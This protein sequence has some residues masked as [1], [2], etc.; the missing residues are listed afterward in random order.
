M[1]INQIMNEIEKLSE[2]ERLEIYSRLASRINKREEILGIL[3]K[4]R[5]KGQGLWGMD[6]QEY[7]NQLRTE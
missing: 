3:E 7:V 5:G 2:K 6:A 1:S 4:Y